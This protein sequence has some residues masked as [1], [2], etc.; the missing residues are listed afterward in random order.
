MAEASARPVETFSIGFEEQEFNELR[1]ARSA[2]TKFRTSHHEMI[3]RPSA[4]EALPVLVE[5]F[6]EPFADSS[7]IPC[8]Y[9][10]E[11]TR[12]HVT[13]A[14]TG[15]AGDEC[16]MGYN[17]YKAVRLAALLDRFP[18]L[19]HLIGARIWQKIPTPANLRSFRRQLQRML[20]GI[21]LP[22]RQRYLHWMSVFPEDD[23][24]ALYTE[25]ALK[26][27]S[28]GAASRFLDQYYAEA[29]GLDPVSATA[30][31]DLCTYLPGDLLVKVDITSM[32]HSLEARSPFLDHPLV[33]LAASLP[34]EMKLRG[35][36]DK[37]I[38]KKAFADLLPEE[39]LRRGKMGFGVPIAHWLRNE[40]RGFLRD[41]LPGKG[42]ESG[43]FSRKTVENLVA[44]HLN[45]T[46]DH[47][48]RLWALLVFELWARRNSAAL[49]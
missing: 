43:P 10:A 17:R 4:L 5:H 39:T 6:D 37:Y 44:E 38:L 14:L 24:R 25:S 22:D 31:V 7:A 33:E 45:E 49:P 47:S 11:M 28:P 21:G 19:R 34:T 29:A 12:K 9:L 3:V 42:C 1:Y 26:L 27:A 40:L 48:H 2:A 20:S 13:V 16:F 41:H 18:P 23:R 32:A 15:D 8:L 30:Y 35:R 46:A 36:R